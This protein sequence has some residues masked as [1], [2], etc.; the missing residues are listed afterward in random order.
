MLLSY[1]IELFE[2]KLLIRQL[3]AVF[4]SVVYMS[5]TNAVFVAF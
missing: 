4:G 2:R 3:F 1:R 5:L